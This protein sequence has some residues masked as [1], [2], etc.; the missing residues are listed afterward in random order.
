MQNKNNVH[1]FIHCCRTFF[2]FMTA[3]KTT[4]QQFLSILNKFFC[5]PESF[6]TNISHQLFDYTI[7]FCTRT[8]IQK[9]ILNSKNGFKRSF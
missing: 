2:C 4:P 7:T 5:L 6:N 9:V 3:N 8:Q 1:Y